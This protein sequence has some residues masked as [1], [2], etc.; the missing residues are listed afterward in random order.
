MYLIWSSKPKARAAN[1]DFSYQTVHD[2][3]ITKVDPVFA[4]EIEDIRK[5]DAKRIA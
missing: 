5:A 2:A 1:N 3:V 4:K